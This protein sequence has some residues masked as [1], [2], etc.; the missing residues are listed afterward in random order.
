MDKYIIV[1]SSEKDKWG[2]LSNLGHELFYVRKILFILYINN[3]IDKEYTIVTSSID[4]SFLY[5]SIF[6]KVLSFK[7]FKKNNFINNENI[8]NLYHCVEYA[9]PKNFINSFNLQ[10]CLTNDCLKA[11]NLNQKY[12][13]DNTIFQ[14][15]NTEI[16]NN[17]SCNNDYIDLN[18][19]DFKDTIQSD[20]YIIHIRPTSKYI[21]YIYDI[22]DNFNM[23]VIIFSQLTN[24]P[25]KYLQTSNLILYGSLL[26]NNNCKF[27]ITEWSGGGQL[28]Q[29]CCKSIII[30][31]YD[32]YEEGYF[33]DKEEMYRDENNKYFHY[34]W[35][36]YTPSHCKRI[37]LKNN[38]F[39]NKNQFLTFL[40]KI[41]IS[42]NYKFY[43]KTY[44]DL[45]HM[46]E[47]EALYHWF[48]HGI[49]EGRICN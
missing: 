7:E 17:L 33:N 16:L 21:D 15:C 47:S 45:K 48:N 31:Y 36:H 18:N 26:N 14:N 42:F 11:L 2:G 5:S 4:R 46:T 10:D 41:Y 32:A 6:K 22:I 35:D 38:E 23:N 20:F 28:A 49:K 27:L 44:S 34:F 40:N 39:N 1:S 37:F 3:L 43:I 12:L 30:Y 25:K 8:I 24:I 19:T 13:C 9:C 29:F